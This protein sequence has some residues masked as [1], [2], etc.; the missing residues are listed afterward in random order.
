[1]PYLINKIIF[2]NFVILLVAAGIKRMFFFT[3]KVS[4]QDLE[5]SV[6][7]MQPCF[8]VSCKLGKLPPSLTIV[9]SV[10]KEN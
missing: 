10:L 4:H 2:Y 8:Y 6:L 9:I 7:P 1:M 5:G 3:L